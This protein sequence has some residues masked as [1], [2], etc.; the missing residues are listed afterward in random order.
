MTGSKSVLNFALIGCGRIAPKHVDALTSGAVPGAKLIAVCDTDFAKAQA[1]GTKLGDVSPVFP[2]ADK[3]AI[4]RMQQMEDQGRGPAVEEAKEPSTQAPV[5]DLPNVPTFRSLNY[6]SLEVQGWSMLVAPK[7]TIPV[8]GL[9]RLEQLLAR[10]LKAETVQTRLAALN[11]TA[12]V[13]SREATADFLKV[14][15]KRYGAIIKARDI[16]LQQP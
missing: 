9:A 16:R 3:S 15:E 6:P 8:E 2:R 11:Q 13:M 1:L 14:E 7:G 4:E 12:V 5:A 10:T